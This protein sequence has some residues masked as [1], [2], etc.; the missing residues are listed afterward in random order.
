MH[1]NSG[2]QK[3]WN[4]EEKFFKELPNKYK[5]YQFRTANL[6]LLKSFFTDPARAMEFP[7]IIYISLFVLTLGLFSTVHSTLVVLTQAASLSMF[8]PFITG[9][10]RTLLST[11]V[12]IMIATPGVVLMWVLTPKISFISTFKRFIFYYESVLLFSLLSELFF[13]KFIIDSSMKI[14]PLIILLAGSIA[15]KTLHQSLKGQP[16]I[17]ITA[18]LIIGILVF[19]Y[20]QSFLIVDGLLPYELQDN[21]D[22]PVTIFIKELFRM[23]FG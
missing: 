8:S 14:Q 22:S 4:E 2:I 7:L 3:K 1:E 17:Q 5:L 21:I 20:I 13:S 11:A 9:C 6:D 15:V 19:S 23:I 12:A 16:N 10:L 18:F